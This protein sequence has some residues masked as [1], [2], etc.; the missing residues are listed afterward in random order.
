ML[1]ER[2]PVVGRLAHVLLV[3]VLVVVHSDPHDDV[4]ALHV[5]ALELDDRVVEVDDGLVD[6]SGAVVLELD[7]WRRR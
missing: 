7:Y 1:R 6:G 2:L 4:A 3:R 5:A